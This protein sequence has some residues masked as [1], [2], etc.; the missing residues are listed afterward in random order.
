MARPAAPYSF[1]DLHPD[2]GGLLDEVVAGLAQPQKA[3][4]PKYF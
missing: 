1:F 2:T 3:L 4:P